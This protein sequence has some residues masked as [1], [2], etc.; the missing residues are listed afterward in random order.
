MP[1]TSEVPDSYEVK[2]GAVIDVLPGQVVVRVERDDA[3]CGGCRSCA[4]RGLC[5]GRDSGH[6][7]LPVAFEGQPPAKTGDQV[8]IAYRAANAAVAALTMFL[9]ALLGLFFG[10][11]IGHRWFG[12]SDGMFLAGCLIGFIL[13]LGVSYVLART[14]ASLKPDVKLLP[15]N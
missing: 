10:G 7:D 11:F 1:D 2:T 3:D 15:Q 12:D 4:V 5:R 8:R 6:M 14:V 13:G 9:P